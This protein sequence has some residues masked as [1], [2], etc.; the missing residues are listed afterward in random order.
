MYIEVYMHTISSYIRIFK[1]VTNE[2]FVLV[3]LLN[4][5]AH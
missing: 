3:L 2:I 1:E 5:N 4:R